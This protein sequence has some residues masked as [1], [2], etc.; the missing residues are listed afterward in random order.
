MENSQLVGDMEK[1]IGVGG[2]VKGMTG[3]VGGIYRFVRG[4]SVGIKHLDLGK[5]RVRISKISDVVHNY[6][7]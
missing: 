2:V 7:Q 5:V 1:Y 6:L 4:D 3:Y